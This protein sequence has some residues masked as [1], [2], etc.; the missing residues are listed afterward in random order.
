M[1]AAVSD[2]EDLPYNALMILELFRW[3]YGAGWSRV[4]HGVGRSVVGVERHFSV[5]IL[6]RT[7]FS[8]WRRIVSYGGRGLDA[9][10]H[11]AMDN[12]I[13]RLVGGF[14][15]GFVLLAALVA[16]AFTGVSV[17]VLAIIW[18]FVPPAIVFLAVKGIT[19]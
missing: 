13:S 1:G 9:Q 7:L 2:I 10:F 6:A 12:L 11:A 18:P 19:G 3:W 5:G 4:L 14:V 15:R 16:M 8:P 17:T